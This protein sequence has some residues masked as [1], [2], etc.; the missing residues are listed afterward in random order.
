MNIKRF[1]IRPPIIQYESL[2]SYLH[3][4][5]NYNMVDFDSIVKMIAND[6]YA[7]RNVSQI[8]RLPRSILSISKLSKLLNMD[9]KSLGEHTFTFVIDKV[10]TNYSANDIEHMRSILMKTIISRNRCFCP[11]C[12][13]DDGSYNVLWQVR[14]IKL[15]DKHSTYLIEYCPKCNKAIPYCSKSLI[16]HKCPSCGY[17]YLNYKSEIEED[18]KIINEQICIYNDWKFMIRHSNSLILGCREKEQQL[19]LKILYVS[20][21]DLNY[22]SK[23]RDLVNHFLFNKLLRMAKKEGTSEQL[24]LHV[25]LDILKKKKI[26]IEEFS[27]MSV[28]ID[29][30][31]SVTSFTNINQKSKQAIG[32]CLSPWCKSF[33]KTDTIKQI[34]S[35]RFH[36][37]NYKL[38]SV[39]TECFMKFGYNRAS[40]KWESISNEVSTTLT[41]KSLLEEG[42]SIRYIQKE[43]GIKMQ[44]FYK[45]YGYLLKNGLINEINTSKTKYA[46]CMDLREK[47]KTINNYPGDRQK[48]A[49]KLYGWGIP[50]YF[51]YLADTQV[52]NYLMFESYEKHISS[53]EKRR[54][55]FKAKIDEAIQLCYK[56]ELE[57]SFENI[58]NFIDFPIQKIKPYNLITYINNIIKEQEEKKI[59]NLLI[60]RLNKFKENHS[61]SICSMAKICKE[62]KLN[63]KELRSKYP[64]LIKKISLKIQVQNKKTKEIQY[65][66]ET[67]SINNAI[68][69]LKENGQQIT[70]KSISELSNISRDIIY[71]RYDKF[72]K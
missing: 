6:G 64:E 25:L 62:L 40:G 29:Y 45:L 37:W 69:I 59:E 35:R 1:T 21:N 41:I 2:T 14:D 26:S 23:C 18:E 49:K 58:S 70:G 19:A 28:P 42:K 36:F 32:N 8:D 34:E 71:Y 16:Q 66:K 44:T 30:I 53:R 39:C 56:S 57:I 65:K 47:F 4:I 43:F 17:I 22:Y 38:S 24:R 33:N 31:N 52:Q 54:L 15:C 3:R 51:Y 10:I 61:N 60:R 11:A 27:K 12:L 9:K 46:E 20:V 13:R 67:D 5:A 50:L 7:R 48:Y 63:E 72:Y 68:N 55:S